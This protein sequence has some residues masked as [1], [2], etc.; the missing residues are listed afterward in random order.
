M[1]DS[2]DTPEA[3]EGWRGQAIAGARSHRGVFAAQNWRDMV[4]DQTGDIESKARD[5]AG[6]A[7]SWF[8]PDALKL[9]T[10]VDGHYSYVQSI[11][12]E[13]TVTWAAFGPRAPDAALSAVLDLAFGKVPRAAEWER[14]FWRRWP[15]PQTG[16]T[17]N[18]PE[19]D[20]TFKADGGWCFVME[21]KWAADLDDAQGTAGS[22]MT[23]LEMRAAVAR[24]VA[25]DESRRGVLVIVP[26]PAKY[27]YARRGTFARYFD[28]DGDRYAPRASARALGAQALTWEQVI[29]IL[30]TIDDENELVRYLEWR[31]SRLPSTMK[32]E[33][34]W[35]ILEEALETV[36]AFRAQLPPKYPR[37]SELGISVDQ[38]ASYDDNRADR[39]WHHLNLPMVL[40]A[41]SRPRDARVQGLMASLLKA[42]DD[43][44]TRF[45][46]VPGMRKTLEPLWKVP[47]APGAPEFWS[48]VACAFLASTYKTSGYEVEAFGA[49]IGD[50][51]KDSDIAIRIGA[52]RTHVDVELWHATK[53]PH[54]DV[55]E[56]KVLLKERAAA[57]VGRKFPD[58]PDDEQGIAAIVC[59]ATGSG[60]QQFT[61][62]ADLAGLV[63][64]DDRPRRYGFVYWLCGLS[65]EGVFFFD[66]RSKPLPVT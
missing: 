54:D 23:Q 7:S 41:R 37:G 56:M 40:Y 30:A 31:L 27:P 66:L 61:S 51:N 60:L 38:V 13:D 2:T 29:E 20:V 28:V 53:L 55:E 48:V 1:T 50:G 46:D 63:Q 9:L 3:I 36:P 62:H 24:A 44:S 12:S 25:H 35:E 19:P 16:R 15:H 43:F 11:N 47:W 14:L 22:S 45:R 33:E 34:L 39:F 18:G 21:A 64:L 32:N 49:K 42:L 4:L 6:R 17:A 5:V 10:S 59:V 52:M 26:G 57:K 58:L 8:A 65:G